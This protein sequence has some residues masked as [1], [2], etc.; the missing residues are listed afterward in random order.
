MAGLDIVNRTR[1]GRSTL[2]FASEI[3]PFCPCP[4]RLGEGSGEQSRSNLNP[5]KYTKKEVGN[6]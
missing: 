2:S 4:V 6:V 1:L 5:M 3:P